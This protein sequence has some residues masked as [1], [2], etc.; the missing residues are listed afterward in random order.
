MNINFGR[1]VCGNLAAAQEREWLVTN[2]LGSYA[3][4]TVAGVLTRCYHGLLVAALKPPLARSLLVTKIDE[5]IQYDGHHHRLFVNRWADDI[6]D[7]NGYWYLE[8]FHL[9]GTIPVWRFA[10]GDALLEKRIWMAAGANI[11]YV[12][13]QL[14]RGSQP[15]VL[16][17]K[18]LVNYR[19]YH[20]RTK[21]NSWRMAVLRRENGMGVTAF[22]GAV[23]FYLLANRGEATI[24]HNWYNNFQLVAEGDRGLFDL[25]DNLYVGTFQ[26]TIAPAG[27]LT[28]VASTEV[29]PS[30][31]GAIALEQR[32]AYE[33]EL[34][35][36]ANWQ[37]APVWINQLVL[38]ADQFIVNRP[39][40]D[41]PEGKTILAGYH[42]FA[43]W[44]RDTMIA[45]PGLTLAT[46]R[47]EI[48]AA[49]L[50]TFGKYVNQGML[51]NNFPDDGRQPDEGSYNTV[52]ATLWY[53]EALRQYYDATGDRQLVAELWSV[54]VEIINWHV[55]GTRYNIHQDS[56][57]GLIYAGKTGTQLTWM[58]AKVDEWVVTPRMG[59]PVEI[60]ALWYNA[61]KT[62]VLFAE[63]LGKPSLEYQA[64]AEVT[65][66]GFQRF[67]NADKGYCFDVLDTPTG[68]DTSLRPNQ[69]FAVSLSESPLTPSQQQQVVEICGRY[70]LTSYGLRSLAPGEAEYQ[71]KYEGDRISRDGAY[72]QGTV[73]GWLIG[74]FAIAHWRVF[75]NPVQARTF[76][77]PMAQHLQN[78][79]LG[80]ISEIFNGNAPI[81]PKGCIAQAW[82]VAEVLRAWR[83][84]GD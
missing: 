23:P 50:R 33:Q 64:M 40:P 84:I 61:L 80:T 39:L 20:S 75:K 57:D 66:K 73:W 83:T 78:A 63:K 51:P 62:M 32:R 53:F 71:G 7:P 14:V 43:D 29:N 69:I 36:R 17:F 48:A 28:F 49:I 26:A 79:G 11:T 41:Q 70:L 25:D 76:L 52:D 4:G 54:L 35:Q 6:V 22:P 77:E 16:S 37:S 30:L 19:D 65:L 55:R 82:S 5:T 67:W 68:N 45:L 44:G 18:V 2:G 21:D 27:N 47:P 10:V 81:Q 58:D 13:Y 9:E 74:A 24:A 12:Y 72:H 38:A 59:K 31:E 15:L 3:S 34:I 56:Q 60:S 1:E 8:S 46:N 42:W